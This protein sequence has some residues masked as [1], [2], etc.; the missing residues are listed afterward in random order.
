MSFKQTSVSMPMASA[1]IMG[2]SPDMKIS[3]FEIQPKVLMVSAL[4]I[5]LIIKVAGILADLS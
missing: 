1:G 3:G 5:V 2:I 4:I